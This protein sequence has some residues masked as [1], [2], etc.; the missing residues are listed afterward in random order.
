MGLARRRTEPR[1][2]VVR[3]GRSRNALDGAGD[4][5]RRTG[6]DLG[7]GAVEVENDHVPVVGDTCARVPISWIISHGAP[8]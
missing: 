3:E 8:P 4:V 7:V 2:R 1:T 5:G 6:H